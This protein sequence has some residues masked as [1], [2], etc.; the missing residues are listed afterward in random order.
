[1]A[2]IMAKRGAKILIYPSLFSLVTGEL[3]FELLLRG[4]A[5]DNQCYVFGVAAARYTQDPKIYQSW[6]HSTGCNPMGKVIGNAEFGEQI[7]ICEIDL[8]TLEANR[9]ELPYV[10]QKRT[11]LY[12]VVDK[13]I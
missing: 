13:K 11:D 4:R 2:Q 10:A 6:A 3:H 7:V 8:E 9:R 12:E 1:M 5:L